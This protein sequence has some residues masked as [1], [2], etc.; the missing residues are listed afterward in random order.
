[1]SIKLSPRLQR[2]ADYVKTGSRVIDVGT[3]HAYIPIWLL[4][5]G[6]CESAFASDIKP[7]PLQ[8]AARD[9]ESAGVSDRLTLL[10][11]DGLSLCTAEDVD[12]VI[13]AGMG[14]ETIMGILS[15]APWAKEKH[16]ILQP[17]TKYF[18]LRA[19]LTEYGCHI[20]DAA[21]TYDTGRIYRVWQVEVGVEDTS[22]WVE[23][24]LLRNHDP[25]LKPYMDDMIKRLHKQIQG[26][27]KAA[28]ADQAQIE[29]LHSELNEYIRIRKE[30]ESW[31]R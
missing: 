9:A 2:I 28:N 14:G 8:N 26:Q 3:D 4:Q 5:N 22:G 6:I 20:A 21:L 1:M 30:A 10:H 19:F 13:I 25:L 27:E 31:Q 7:G 29:A 17:Q 11:C 16:L 24:P 23:A 12:T 18:E 15:A